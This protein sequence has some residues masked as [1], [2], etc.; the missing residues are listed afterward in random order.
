[1]NCTELAPIQPCGGTVYGYEV[2]FLVELR[3]E[4]ETKRWH[5]KGSLRSLLRAVR[6]VRGFRRVIEAVEYT[7]EQ[8]RRVFGTGSENGAVQW[9]DRQRAA[10]RSGEHNPKFYAAGEA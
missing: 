6:V 7:E 4:E 8:Y 3:G 2:S 5:R 1:M 10:A 9:R